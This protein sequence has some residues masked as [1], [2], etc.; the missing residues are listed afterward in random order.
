[1]ALEQ[2]PRQGVQRQRKGRAIVTAIKE[3]NIKAFYA[4]RI[5]TLRGDYMETTTDRDLGSQGTYV[6]CYYIPFQFHETIRLR[7]SS[8][9]N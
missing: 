9:D 8:G 2:L 5:V 1:M 6:R 3:I 7:C 4:A